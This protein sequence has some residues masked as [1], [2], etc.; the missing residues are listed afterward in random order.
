M[1]RIVVREPTLVL[2]V[3]AAA[4]ALLVSFQTPWMSADQAPLVVAVVAA[5]LAIINGIVVRP[6]QPAIFTGAITATAALLAGYGLEL[7]P[8][9]VGSLVALVGP[10]LALQTRGQV[11]PTADP[12]P[13][14]QVVG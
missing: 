8:E 11:T 3:V 5:V 2:Q 6:W 9:L 4:L 10:L 1:P 12:R 13:A 14:E 7:R